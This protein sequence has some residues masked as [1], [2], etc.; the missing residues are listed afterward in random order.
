MRRFGSMGATLSARARGVG[1]T[2][3]GGEMAA[4]SVSHEFTFDHDTDSWAVI[5]RS[6]LGLAEGVGGRLRSAGILANTVAV[7]IRDSDFVTITRQRTLD[8]PTDFDRRH[9]ARCRG[10]GATRGQGHAG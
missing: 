3:V 6:L 8:D 10:F 4:K 9:L 7:K 5:E 1:D 2:E